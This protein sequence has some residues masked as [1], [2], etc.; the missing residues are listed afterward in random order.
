MRQYRT[1]IIAGAC[2]IALLLTISL[3]GGTSR[4]GI[5]KDDIDVETQLASSDDV[6]AFAV[7]RPQSSKCSVTKLSMLYG[8]HRVPQLEHALLTHRRHSERWGC[9]YEVLER[10]LTSRKL[11]SKQYYLMSI[12]LRE[13]AKPIEERQEWLLWVDADSM[14]LNPALSPEIFLPPAHLKDVYALATA[15]HNGLNSG[16]FYLRVHPL[17]LD[18]L[19]QTVAY[20]LSHPEDD[21]GWF[22]EQAAMAKVIES[23]E[24]NQTSQAYPGIVWMPRVWF[25]A[26]EFEFGFEGKPGHMMV[27]FAGLGEKRLLHISNWLEILEQTP[28]KWEAPLE[29]TFYK[30]AISEFWT[31][32]EAN[33]TKRS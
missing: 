30:T 8:T 33:Y 3:L 6:G 21:L 20:P 19:T 12:M 23:R 17:A 18:L 11:F 2:T 4:V 5:L 16:I 32:F 24:T 31:D 14:I 26:Y 9:G 28:G 7:L 13:L 22:S 29:K 15:D 10:D 1:R 27:H 25:N